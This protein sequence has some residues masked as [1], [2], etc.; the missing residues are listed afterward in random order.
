M[1][2]YKQNNQNTWS[3][4]NSR[5]IQIEI[6]TIRTSLIIYNKQRLTVFD[7]ETAD[8][9]TIRTLKHKSIVIHDLVRN[10][11]KQYRSIGLFSNRITVKRL[12]SWTLPR[13]GYDEGKPSV[14]LFYPWESARKDDETI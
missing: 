6:Q 5:I 1:M 7:K 2:Q 10:E 12:G 3:I 8:N 14:C 9:Y 4:R 11:K 13:S